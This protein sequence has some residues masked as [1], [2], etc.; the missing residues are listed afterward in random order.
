MN[1]ADFYV[2]Q[3]LNLAVCGD[4][5][6]V[7]GDAFRLIVYTVTEIKNGEVRVTWREPSG[8]VAHPSRFYGAHLFEPAPCPAI[9]E[10]EEL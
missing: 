3:R 8:S 10:E 2:G 7:I 6:R 1:A 9:E 5:S 4:A